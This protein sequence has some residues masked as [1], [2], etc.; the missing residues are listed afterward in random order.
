LYS[1]LES[2]QDINVDIIDE[3][4]STTLNNEIFITDEESG[5][6]FHYMS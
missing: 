4:F 1:W 5:A 6:E 3:K 2:Q